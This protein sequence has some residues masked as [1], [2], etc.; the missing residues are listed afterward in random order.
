[1][2]NYYAKFIPNLST[3]SIE[4]KAC[5]LEMGKRGERSI[6]TT[7]EAFTST[8]VLIHYNPEWPIKLD[9]DASAVGIG[10]V[11][12][13]VMPDGTERP[14]A[15]ASTSLNQAE[16]NYSQIE[17]EAL[18]LVWGVKLPPKRLRNLYVQMA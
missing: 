14:I 7:R 13:H 15:Y 3:V 6:S 4:A 5:L 1:M 2:I 16:R 18:S 12:S 11:P 17:K 10:A 9:C 8:Q